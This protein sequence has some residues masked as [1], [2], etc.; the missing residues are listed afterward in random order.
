[1]TTK[2]Y[3]LELNKAFLILHLYIHS[4]I[5]QNKVEVSIFNSDV[6]E[7][8]YGLEAGF[9]QSEARKVIFR[10]SKHPNWPC[11][12]LSLHCN[13]CLKFFRRSK[14]ASE[15]NVTAHLQLM[16]SQY[17]I[18]SLKRRAKGEYFELWVVFKSFDVS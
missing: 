5:N 13:T 8:D 3:E 16:S 15:W 17:K 7:I 10:N 6:T 4:Y 12:P 2:R 1:M 14:S 18:T 11:H 9:H